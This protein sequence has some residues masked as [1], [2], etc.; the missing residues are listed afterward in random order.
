MAWLPSCTWPTGIRPRVALE[1]E[2]AGMDVPSNQTS[3]V[4]TSP[5]MLTCSSAACHVPRLRVGTWHAARSEEHTSELQSRSDLVC[6]LLL[7][8][9]KKL[10]THT[11]SNIRVLDMQSI[12]ITPDD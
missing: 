7:E 3:V 2:K 6:R 9:K 5:L 1:V 11:P 8:K 4:T 12:R 10:N